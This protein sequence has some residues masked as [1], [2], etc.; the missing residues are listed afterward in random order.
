MMIFFRKKVESLQKLTNSTCSVITVAQGSTI[1]KLS[2]NPIGGYDVIL[3]F[4]LIRRKYKNCCASYVDGL[5][6]E[7][8]AQQLSP[9][10]NSTLTKV[11]GSGV[12]LLKSQKNMDYQLL[13]SLLINKRF[14]EAN[15]LTHRILCELSSLYCGRRSWLYFTDVLSLP[16]TDLHTIDSLWRVHSLNKFGFSIQRKIWLSSN[17]NWSKMWK[18]IGWKTNHVFCRYPNDFY[19]NMDAPTGH[20]PLFNQLYGVQ[21]LLALLKHKAWETYE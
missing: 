10:I 11:F 1:Q 8:L 6:Y 20:L 12:V 21:P 18:A 9:R 5:I 15:M 16:I 13:Q 17:K 4:L 7:I 14:Q 3:H 19:W 2:Q